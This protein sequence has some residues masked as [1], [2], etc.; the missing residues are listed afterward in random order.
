MGSASGAEEEANPLALSRLLARTTSAPL[1]RLAWTTYDDT[2]FDLQL[3]PALSSHPSIAALE[4]LELTTFLRDP[5]LPAA[6][7]HLAGPGAASAGTVL[8]RLR[9][10]RLSLA[11]A[12]F[13]ILSTWALPALRNLCDRIQE[14]TR[15]VVRRTL[16]P[17]LPALSADAELVVYRVAQEALTNVV[18]HART[19]AAEVK[20][21]AQDREI[22]LCVHDTGVGVGEHDAEDSSGGIRGMRE[23]ALLIGARLEVVPASTGGTD[24]RLHVPLTS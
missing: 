1:K 10:L 14:G 13:G 24:V 15:L 5:P 19:D 22:E 20:L 6:P 12:P 4:Y 16:E 8:P 23:R 3:A 21:T 7:A 18:R 9:A 17:D 11:D 2:P